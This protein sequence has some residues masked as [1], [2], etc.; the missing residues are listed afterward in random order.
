MVRDRGRVARSRVAAAAQ[1]RL[2]LRRRERPQRPDATGGGDEPEHVDPLLAVQAHFGQLV[3][4][5]ERGEDVAL[6]VE[7]TLDVGPGE[8][9]LAGRGEEPLERGRRAHD[10]RRG[11]VRRAEAGA[12][13]RLDARPAGRRPGG[14]R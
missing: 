3:A 4:E 12:V 6:D 9:E 14:L 5:R 7:V 2:L 10:E 1:A 8:A 11:G 13:V